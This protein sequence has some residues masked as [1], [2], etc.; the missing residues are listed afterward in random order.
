[1]LSILP[2]GR[3]FILFLRELSGRLLPDICSMWG[4]KNGACQSLYSQ[5]GGLI[6]PPDRQNEGIWNAAEYINRY[7]HMPCAEP[8]FQRTG[9]D[10]RFA[11]P[12]DRQARKFLDE[13]HRKRKPERKTVMSPKNISKKKCKQNA[14]D[15]IDLNQKEIARIGDAIFYF[16]ELGMQELRTSDYTAD[17][18]YAA[19]FNVKKGISE[20]PPAWMATWGSGKPVIGVH[21]E[22]DALPNCSQTP[23]ITEEKP[24]IAGGAPGH[25]EGHNTNMAVM[26]GGAVAARKT[27]ERENIKGTLKLYFAPAEEQNISRPYFMRD[28]YFSGL[29][30]VFHP[31]VSSE[32]TTTYGIRQFANISAEFIFHGQSAH[33]AVAPWKAKNALDAATLMDVGWGLMRQQLKPSQR[34]HR[35]ILDG[36]DQPNVIPSYTR[37]WWWFREKDMELANVNFEKAKKIAQGA[38][39]MTDCSFETKITSTS[40]PTRA[41]QTMAEIIQKNIETVGIPEW[42]QKEDA[43]A[44]KLQKKI[45]VPVVGLQKEIKPLREARQKTSC[46]DSGCVSWVIPTGRINFP[47]NIPGYSSHTWPAGVSLTTS[48]AHKACANGAKVLAASILDLF[49]D[50][51]LLNEAKRTF[52]KEIGKVKHFSI[53]PADQKPPLDLNRNEMEKWRPLMEK[54]YVKEKVEWK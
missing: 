9:S 14:F 36:G 7:S 34:S 42:S 5:T 35:V 18:L 19:G 20:M 46:N 6:F 33:S 4:S 2:V 22:A 29:D 32:L 40:W 23:G 52:K 10:Y 37:V 31:H 24:L 44:R 1:V 16:A 49:L 53:L 12:L 30:A 25:E 17:A 38:A 50:R 21:C 13:N 27:M 39:M 48:I 26:I 15:F 45:R 28:G 47:S 51:K 11:V 54:F 8:L 41:N 43:L 3:S